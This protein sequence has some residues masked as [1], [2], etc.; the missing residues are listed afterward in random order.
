MLTKFLVITFLIVLSAFFTI[1]FF[2]KLAGI[3]IFSAMGSAK[4]ISAGFIVFYITAFMLFY[5]FFFLL[6][7][8]VLD[9]K[10]YHAG[11]LSGYRDSGNKIMVYDP[12]QER[13]V[14]YVQYFA[15]LPADKFTE[16]FKVVSLFKLPSD[17]YYQDTETLGLGN[18]LIASICGLIMLAVVYIILFLIARDSAEARVAPVELTHRIIATRFNTIVGVA[19]LKA[20][21]ILLS[22]MALFF[23]FNVISVKK[24]I[25]HYRGLYASP[26][27]A[28]MDEL[29]KK[30]SPGKTLTGT[31]TLRFKERKS[32]HDSDYSEKRD[33][34]VT[35]YYTVLHYT[36]E[37][38]DLLRIP[39]YLT[40]EL[41]DGRE[42][43][44]ILDG[45]FANRKAVAPKNLKEYAFIVNKDYSISLKR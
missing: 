32:E 29:L 18:N 43:V 39:V 11:G 8:R 20:L 5:M 3:D 9:M 19:P 6:P 25:G 45:Q 36:V 14:G 44:K 17:D 1:K 30:V 38:K 41:N 42:E 12:S 33:R 15:Q 22:F 23:G 28:L 40:L 2:G 21:I 13:Y 7:S 27:Q 31:V 35:T 37:F 26:R 10:N 16:T 34:G 4:G 24:I